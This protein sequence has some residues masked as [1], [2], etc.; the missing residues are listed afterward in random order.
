MYH[1]RSED[2]RILFVRLTDGLSGSEYYNIYLLKELQK[3][4]DISVHLITNFQPFIQKIQREQIPCSYIHLPIKEIGT[5]RE[6]LIGF[7]SFIPFLL[8]FLHTLRNLE[9][10][11]KF[12]AIILES[13]TEKIFLTLLLKLLHYRVVWIEHGPFFRTYRFFLVKWLYVLTSNYVHSIIVVS[14][15]TKTDLVTHGIESKKVHCVYIGIDIPRIRVS[16]KNTR[17]GCFTIGFLGSITKE[18]GIKEFLDT[19]YALLQKHAYASFCI[20]GDG[21]LLEW[22]KQYVRILKIQK[23]VLFTGHVDDISNYVQHID[24]MYFP[25]RHLE[26]LSLAILESLA[27]GKII[28]ARDIGGNRELVVNKKTGFLFQSD[29]EGQEIL[30]DILNGKLS[31]KG[32]PEA[33]ITH[34]RKHFLMENQVKEFMKVFHG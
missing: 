7:R 25:T 5:G 27:M 17:E 23:N 30:E 12:H 11:K 28:V 29:E 9:S 10:D 2:M 34:V 3:Q 16:H 14:Q 21:P 20:I 4:Q 6:L 8:S 13:T 15:D 19:A 1:H 22:A 18:K 26:G 32:I 33:A 24:T 31:V